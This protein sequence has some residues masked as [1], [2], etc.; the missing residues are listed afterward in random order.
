MCIPLHHFPY[1]MSSQISDSQYTHAIFLPNTTTSMSPSA[2]DTEFLNHMSSANS[3]DNSFNS[4]VSETN[5]NESSSASS[6][7]HDNSNVPEVRHSTRT[8]QLPTYLSSYYC[9]LGQVDKLQSTHWCNLVTYD[10]NSNSHKSFLSQTNSISEPRNYNEVVCQPIWV[11]AMQNELKA[12]SD[13]K[14][15]ELVD[16][17]KDKK[18]IGNK[19]VYKVK[20]HAYGSLERCKARLVAKGYNKK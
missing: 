18:A 15:W 16:L 4:S 1:H 11:E 5:H 13:N 7:S 14:M 20:L 9:N 3:F 12:L 19:W 6:F 10:A 17:P 2:Y 8:R